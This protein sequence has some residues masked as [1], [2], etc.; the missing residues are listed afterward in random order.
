MM[1][2][3]II[4]DSADKIRDI[5]GLIRSSELSH[6][7]EIVTAG[8]LYNARRLMRDTHFGLVILDINIP[9]RPGDDPT[10][11]SCESFLGDVG[12]GTT[13]KTPGSL[14]GL[15]AFGDLYEK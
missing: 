1:R 11:S 9:A 6:V 10:P 5:A 2:V 4:D 8:D 12:K 13:L 3:L 15:T 14:I 7:V